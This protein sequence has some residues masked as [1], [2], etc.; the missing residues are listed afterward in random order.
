V[1]FF[2]IFSQIVLFFAQETYKKPIILRRNKKLGIPPLPSPFPT[3]KAKVKFL[4]TI[5]LVRPLHMLVVEPIVGF[6]SLYTAFN[7]AV[8]FC[9]FAAF[10]YVFKSVYHFNTEQAGLVFLAI[11]VGCLLSVATILLCDIYL[12][13]PQVRLSHSEGRKGVVP[14]E[15][16]LYPAMLGSFGLPIGLFWF[17]WTA[18]SDVSWASPVV[19]AIPFAW[20]NLSIF[21]GISHPTNHF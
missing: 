16:R 10:P 13:Q 15:Y 18:R 5:A 17:A 2:A 12:Y 7:F 21:T 11:G 3:T 20:G 8:L 19:S 9:F 6:L 4:V 1:I 14:P